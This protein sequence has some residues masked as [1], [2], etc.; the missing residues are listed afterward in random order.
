ME[1]RCKGYSLC[2]NS[3]KGQITSEN[4]FHTSPVKT[5]YL[6]SV[7]VTPRDRV[8][9]TSENRFHTLPIKAQYLCNVPPG[10]LFPMKDIH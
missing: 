2:Y 4:R 8:D 3:A 7:K 1:W 10:K 5:Q 9:I 6:C